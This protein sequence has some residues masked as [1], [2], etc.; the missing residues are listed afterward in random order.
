MPASHRT[1]RANGDPD[2]NSA[3]FFAEILAADKR[4]RLAGTPLLTRAGQHYFTGL[5]VAFGAALEISRKL[6]AELPDQHELRNQ[7]A[8][9]LVNLAGLKGEQQDFRT[10]CRLLEE[11]RPHHQAA[12]RALPEHPD[13]RKFWR[14][15]RTNLCIALLGLRDHEQLAKAAQELAA[16]G[17]DPADD[18][19]SAAGFVTHCS[20]LAKSDDKLAAATRAELAARHADQAMALLQQ[21][22][23]RASGTPG[24]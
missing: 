2:P 8:G 12:L 21:A 18:A 19:Y 23:A 5:L 1:K 3:V 7:L 15:N 20:V 13:Y 11:A 6:V 14:N 17:F 9:L 10:A 24:E 4:A 16:N 22:V